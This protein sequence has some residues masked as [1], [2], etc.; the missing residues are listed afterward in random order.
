MPNLT[1]SFASIFAIIFIFALSVLTHVITF[2]KLHAELATGKKFAIS[3][4]LSNKNSFLTN[5]D[6][7]A[8]VLASSL[9]TIL[10]A[11]GVIKSIAILLTL[12]SLF[13]ALFTLVV[14][15]GLIKMYSQINSTKFDKLG[16]TKVE[17]NN[18]K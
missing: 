6:L 18:E 16:F 7:L 2:N 14:L 1:I 17:V 15:R 9:I 4:K 3:F 12:G 8:P 13:A 10:F 11:S 5:I